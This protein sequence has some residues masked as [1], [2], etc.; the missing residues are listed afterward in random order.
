MAITEP[1]LSLA[2]RGVFLM[3]YH[4]TQCS[5]RDLILYTACC[6]GHSGFTGA[7]CYSLL[8]FGCRRIGCDYVEKTPTWLK[9]F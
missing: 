6:S 1:H 5:E 8:A 7:W 3:E 9:T 2:C 4:V